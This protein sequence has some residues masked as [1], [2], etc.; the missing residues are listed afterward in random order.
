MASTV[1]STVLPV[2]WSTPVDTRWRDVVVGVYLNQT[3]RDRVVAVVHGAVGRAGSPVVVAS[4]MS[5]TSVERWLPGVPG[6]TSAAVA[7]SFA[8]ATAAALEGSA[9]STH[10][11]SP[12]R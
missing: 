3:L 1:S 8:G 7:R 2:P 6:M 12:A 11:A 10:S 5:A 9:S 4:V